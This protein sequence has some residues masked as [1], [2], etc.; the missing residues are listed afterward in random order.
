MGNSNK[1]S[2]LQIYEDMGF[3]EKEWKAERVGRWSILLFILAGLAGLFGW[4]P[5]SKASNRD[6][7][8][9]AWVE[10]ERFTRLKAPV[11]LKVHIEDAPII[12]GESSFW[13]DAEYLRNFRI[14]YI[15]PE[16][17]STEVGS[18]RVTY[19]FKVGPEGQLDEV[20][21]HLEPETFGWIQGYIGIEDS[22][23]NSFNQ[24]IYP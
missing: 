20:L 8:Q 9:M 21:F 5:M 2:S 19:N 4:G 1:S 17:D 7:G 3:Q 15:Y 23:G 22:E 24:L 18:R 16:P 11:I 13:L 6:T 14:H 12:D 10:Y